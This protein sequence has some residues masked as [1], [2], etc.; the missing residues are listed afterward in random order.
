MTWFRTST[1]STAIV[2]ASREQ[3]WAALTDPVLLPRLTPFLKRIT[4]DGDHWTWELSGISIL[5]AH[6]SP[7]FTERMTFDEP[8]RIEYRHD[9][10]KGARERAGVE[11]W[12][13]LKEA[14]QGRTE[15]S[16][17]LGVEVD[18]PLPKAAGPAVRTAMKGVIGT[19]GKK[20]S[21]NLLDHLGAR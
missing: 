9:P 20:F 7:T 14:G 6:V 18:L 15:L 11:G 19:M 3:V 8:S 4:V 12:Y 2:R 1:E 21:A 13:A 17:S 16:I 10:A 5:G